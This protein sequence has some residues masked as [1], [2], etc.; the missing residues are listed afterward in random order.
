[1]RYQITN[2]T[3]GIN[4]GT[5]TASTPE[6]ALDAMARAAGYA[7]HAAACQVAPVADGELRVFLL[8]ERVGDVNLN[9]NGT[10]TYWSTYDQSWVRWANAISDQELAAMTLEERDATIAH[11]DRARVERDKINED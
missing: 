11:L 1:M 4:L 9:G 2:T 10:V 7:D 5:Y 3:S 8:S 6:G